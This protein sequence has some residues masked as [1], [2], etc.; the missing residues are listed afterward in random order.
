MDDAKQAG[1]KFEQLVTI[2]DTLRGEGGCPWDR[3][4]DEKSITNYFLEEVFEAVDAVL[5]RDT[6]AIAE[7][8]GDV[9]MEIVF[10]ARIYKEKDA[11]TMSSVVEKI[12]EKMIRRHPHVF[13]E[14]KLE[15]SKEVVNDWI[16]SKK[17]EKRQSSIF[18]GVSETSP[19]LHAAYQIGLRASSVG[20]DW[21]KPLAALQKVK[22]EVAELENALESE[23]EDDVL[24]EMGDVL[25]ALA[26]VSRLSGRNPEIC[27]RKA[28]EKFIM[29]F[30]E[31]ENKLQEEGKKL[32]DAGLE[33]MDAIWD[34]I[35]SS[36]PKSQE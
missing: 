3:K 4:Q 24:Q 6:A 19:A 7:E 31:V 23:K 36:T 5:S 30:K 17:R 35:K 20:F 9:L 13:G 28:N 8:L 29:R 10:L 15:N 32:E 16:Q 14:K 27:L 22:E 21:E 26:N 12:N 2:L 34:Q 25:F 18:E 1:N 11:F 33:E